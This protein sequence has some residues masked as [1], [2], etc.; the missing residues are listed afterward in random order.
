MT[1]KKMF[2]FLEKDEDG[3]P[4]D[5][6][7]TVW[8]EELK[9]NRYRIDNIPFYIRD[10]SP[11]DIVTGRMVGENLVF[12]EL[13]SKSMISVFRIVFFDKSKAEGVLSKLVRAG[14]RW[15]GS[16]LANFY[17][18]EL[19]ASVNIQAI[20]ESLDIEASK[21]VLDYEEASIRSR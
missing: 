19:P 8:V 2:F 12:D 11:E 15:E 3:Y 17:S 16:H 1:K 14:C 20:K 18:V 13:L 9:G 4:P 21:D 6:S 7:E 5:D 10:I